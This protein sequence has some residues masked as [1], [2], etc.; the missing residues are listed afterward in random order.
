MASNLR[1]QFLDEASS[2]KSEKTEIVFRRMWKRIEAIEKETRKTLDEGFSKGEYTALLSK[3]N[4]SA[5]M[6]FNVN[7]SIVMKYVSWLVERGVLDN[8]YVDAISQLRFEDVSFAGEYAKKYF[9][10]FD[11][12][13]EAIEDTILIAERV[14][15]SQFDTIVSA[16]YLSWFGIKSETI[17]QIKKD[18]LTDS[19][20]VVNGVEVRIPCSILDFL[21][22]YAVA[23]GFQ[24]QARGLITHKYVPSSYLLRTSKREQLDVKTLRTILAHFTEICED[25][26]KF[27]LDR[28]YWSGIYSRAYAYE[29]LNGSL[30]PSD[31]DTLEKVFNETYNDK[32]VANKRLRSYQA[33]KN[34]Y[35]D[36]T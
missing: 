21:K 15:E 2:N 9:K 18:D 32:L 20:V 35:Y 17:C 13:R 19:G 12:L 3:L 27:H 28:I 36:K 11:M 31:Y 14:D 30:Q 24:Q 29:I 23:E 33:Y 16:M 1:I 4:S 6:S 25:G 8:E 7:K 22:E 34:Y 5:V 10:D 26:F